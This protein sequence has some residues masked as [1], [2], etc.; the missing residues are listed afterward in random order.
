MSVEQST[1]LDELL[2]SPEFY[3]DPYPAFHR[4]RADAPVHFRALAPLIVA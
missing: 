1:D 4:L 2:T 3:R